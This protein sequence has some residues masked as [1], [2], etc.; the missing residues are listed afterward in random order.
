MKKIGGLWLIGSILLSWA[1]YALTLAFP[2]SLTTLYPGIDGQYS[3]VNFNVQNGFWG[4]FFWRNNVT[5]APTTVQV[6]IQTVTGCTQQ[7]RGLYYNNQRW[8][9]LWPID[10]NTLTGLQTIDSGYNAMTLTGGLF[11]SCSGKPAGAVYGAVTQYRGNHA[12]HIIGGVNYDFVNKTWLPTFGQTL[13]K[14]S[15]TSASGWIFDSQG[16]IGQMLGSFQCGNTIIEAWEQCDDGNQNNNDSCSN[17]CTLTAQPVCG[18]A[19]LQWAEQCDDGNTNNNDGC[20]AQCTFE[21]PQT[22]GLSGNLVPN[23][24]FES[25]IQCPTDFSHFTWYAASWYSPSPNA[26][27]MR[28]GCPFGTWIASA[29]QQ[30][31]HGGSSGMVHI[32][33]YAS[34]IPGAGREYIAAQLVAPMQI[35]KRYNVWFCYATTAISNYISDKIGMLFS[36]GTYPTNCIWSAI[37]QTPQFEHTVIYSM[38]MMD[39][40]IGYYT[41][42]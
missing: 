15:N 19:I 25:Y 38:N 2:N 31:P 4:M 42:W 20:S 5:V 41:S 34:N 40:C 17:T 26:D 16:A 32:L 3:P 28:L 30:F 21:I 33:T 12:F 8:A 9:R 10:Q 24:W 37:T 27:Y 1:T 23:P 29:A 35:G 36:T 13:Y 7:L 22:C 18:N 39:V 11:T 14:Y 6:G